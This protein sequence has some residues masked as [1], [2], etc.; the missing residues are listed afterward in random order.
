MRR[1]ESG[2][3]IL[4]LP[5]FT[6]AITWLIV[7]NTAF[8]FTQS[9]LSSSRSEEA[10][11]EALALVPNHVIH[12]GRIWELVTYSVLHGDLWHWFFNMLWLWLFGARVEMIRGSRYFLELFLAGVIGGGLF[13]IGLAYTHVLG[14]PNR[15]TIGASAGVFAVLLAFGMFF[16]ET[17]IHII[18]LPILIKAKY[19][20]GIMMITELAMSLKERDGI[21][22]I[23]HVGGVVFGYLFIKLVPRRGFGFEMSEGVFSLRNFYHKLKRRRASRKFEVYMRKQGQNPQDS[24]DDSK[25]PPP[26]DKK[27]DRG[28]WVN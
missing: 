6:P 11:L 23:A 9:V 2:P 12:H 28:G 7:V 13:D 15:G 14:D 22:H 10:L 26:D 25:F 17:E 3:Q 1:I 19:L 27:D 16:G 8:Y 18:P 5:P 24:P 21:A 20:I 4:S